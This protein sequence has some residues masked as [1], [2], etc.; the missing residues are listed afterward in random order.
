[1]ARSKIGNGART[2]PRSLRLVSI[3]SE[4]TRQGHYAGQGSRF[5][6]GTQNL[7]TERR[8]TQHRTQSR[9]LRKVESAKYGGA[10]RYLGHPP[11]PLDPVEL[12]YE[13]SQTSDDGQLVCFD[14]RLSS[15]TYR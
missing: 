12:L 5:Q 8:L 1:M 11:Q 15:P 7:D 14:A 6:L 4:F 10:R 13:P 9:R 3:L 2:T